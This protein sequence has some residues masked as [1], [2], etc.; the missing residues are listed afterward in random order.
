MAVETSLNPMPSPIS[1]MMFLGIFSL[2]DVS[3]AVTVFSLT[4]TEIQED[5]S[6]LKDN[7]NRKKETLIFILKFLFVKIRNKKG[8]EREG[9]VN[10]CPLN[11]NGEIVGSN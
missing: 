6:R 2:T 3:A 8:L 11:V 5:V 7:A 9:L 10:C 4:L 1:R